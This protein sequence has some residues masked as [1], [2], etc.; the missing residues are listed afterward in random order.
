MKGSFGLNIYFA[1]QP[2]L[3]TVPCFRINTFY[4]I[5]F[6]VLFIVILNQAIYW[7]C[8]FWKMEG[9]QRETQLFSHPKSYQFPFGHSCV[10]AFLL[11]HPSHKFLFPFISPTRQGKAR[12]FEIISWNSG[13]RFQC[14]SEHHL[15]ESRMLTDLDVIHNSHPVKECCYIFSPITTDH[16]SLEEKETRAR[17]FIEQRS[18]ASDQGSQ[19]LGNVTRS[20]S[21]FLPLRSQK[22]NHEQTQRTKP[23]IL[24]SFS[25]ISDF[26]I[27]PQRHSSFSSSGD[28]VNYIGAHFK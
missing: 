24:G 9:L 6:L 20:I 5:Y 2:V 13:S 23:R 19:N 7:I 10:S 28:T 15:F 27:Q 18:I 16:Y 22:A 14:I 17:L 11:F 12:H 25:Y 4:L 26:L 1:I 3:A 21:A 8:F